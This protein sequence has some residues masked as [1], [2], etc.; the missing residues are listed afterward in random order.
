MF[1]FVALTWNDSNS[2]AAASARRLAQRL[3]SSSAGWRRDVHTPGLIVLH[4]G[5]RHGSSEGYVLSSNQGIVLGKLFRRSAGAAQVSSTLPLDAAEA[6]AVVRSA[7]RRL[8]EEYWGRYVAFLH[9][10]VRG[11]TWVVRDPTGDLPCYRVACEDVNVYFSCAE[12]CAALDLLRFAPNWKYVAA[13]MCFPTMVQSEETGLEDVSEVQ[14]GECWET[15]GE[16]PI[17]KT[18]LWNP[19]DIAR[20]DAI[21]VFDA[22]VDAV[23]QTTQMCVWSWAE[24]HPRI[25]HLLSG[26]LDSSVVL[27]CLHTAPS[28]PHVTCLNYFDA[29]SPA[30]DEREYARLAA[31]AAGCRIVESPLGTSDMKLEPLLDMARSVKPYLVQYYVNHSPLEGRLAAEESATALFYGNGGDQIFYQNPVTLI[32]ADYA[33]QHGPRI[34]LLRLAAQ[35]A[36]STRTSFWSVLG[37]ALRNGLLRKSWDPLAKTQA[38]R[39]LM[40]NPQVM[41]AVQHRQEYLL[42]PFLKEADGMSLGKLEHV[43]MLCGWRDFFDPLETADYPERI[44]PLVSQPLIE[45]CLRIPTYVLAAEGRDR[46]VAR[47]AFAQELPQRI[48]SRRAKGIIDSSLSQLLRNNWAFLKELMLDGMLVKE[49][50]LDRRKIEDLFSH[51]RTSLGPEAQELVVLH[52]STEA[53]LRSWTDRRTIPAAAS[54]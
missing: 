21:E 34:G 35:V 48:R 25:V 22:A 45:L 53:W 23:R 3:T 39:L 37:N 49:G 27:A 28:R 42:R 12:D 6:S 36:L 18:L 14:P 44:R 50:L 30:G 54:Y 46:A 43:R 47:K 2:R 4:A 20:F 1:R 11:R 32:A 31:T 10:S 40:V 17:R 13:F 52:L 51:G 19:V 33:R 29:T 15:D 5:T 24:C 16:R 9:D 38:L 26:G 41:D 7:G 8:I